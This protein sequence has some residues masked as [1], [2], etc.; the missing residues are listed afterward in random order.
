MIYQVILEFYPG[1]EI[2]SL[3]KHG[4]ILS[5]FIK[6]VFFKGKD[7]GSS[8]TIDVFYEIANSNHV[9]IAT[10]DIKTLKEDFFIDKKDIVEYIVKQL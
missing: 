5:Y 4:V 1:K 9:T 7:D 6:K 3:N 10:V 8:V 2:Y